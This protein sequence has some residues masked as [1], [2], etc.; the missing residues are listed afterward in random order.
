MEK[1]PF[2]K[3]PNKILIEM[4]RSLAFCERTRIFCAILR[5]T[6]GWNKKEDW[7]ALSQFEDLTGMAKPNVCRTLKKMLNEKIIIKMDNKYRINDITS[8]WK[9]LSKRTPF[10]KSDKGNYQNGK[11]AL[12]KQIPTK[13]TLTKNSFLQ[14]TRGKTQK[15][16]ES[17]IKGRMTEQDFEK[18]WRAY[19]RK[20]DKRRCLK[21]FI[22]LPRKLMP[23]ILLAVRLHDQS[24]N[25]NKVD[26]VFIPYP[27][28]WIK[29]KR[30]DDDVDIY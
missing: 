18:F 25:W 20:V 5:K 6:A 26:G 16:F 9:A 10:I 19:P 3:I 11:S 29:D 30:W 22:K 12:S 4:A 8:R 23:E 15:N 2:T 1:E 17:D 7:I 27:S 28:N 21:H 24:E 13:D 14:N